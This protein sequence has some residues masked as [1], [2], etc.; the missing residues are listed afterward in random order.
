M[1][2]MYEDL[3]RA[4]IDARLADARER[5]VGVQLARS[6][7][8]ARQAKRVNEQVRLVLARSV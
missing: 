8:L 5:R 1:H 6:R 3:A 7:R 2:L 4:H